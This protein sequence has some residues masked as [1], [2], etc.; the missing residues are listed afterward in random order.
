MF[1]CFDVTCVKTYVTWSGPNK[2][3]L[4]HSDQAEDNSFTVCCLFCKEGFKTEELC[5]EQMC[6]GKLE[7]KKQ[8]ENQDKNGSIKPSGEDE[9]E[10]KEIKEKPKSDPK[11]PGNKNVEPTKKKLK[12]SPVLLRMLRGGSKK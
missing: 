1:I 4:K 5:D 9:V 6:A 7:H 2:H 3:K 12:S 10:V 8:I 11:L